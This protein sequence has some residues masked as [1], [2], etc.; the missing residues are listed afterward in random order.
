M[1]KLSPDRELIAIHFNN[2]SIAPLTDVPYNDMLSY[3]KAYREFSKIIDNP[4]MAIS[5]KLSPGDCFLVDNTR[6]LHARTAI[7]GTGSRWLQGCYA[8]KDGLL[9][10]ILTNTL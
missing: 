3:Y 5:F 9:S 1:I 4:R 2:R 6:V 10:T 7:T 8:D